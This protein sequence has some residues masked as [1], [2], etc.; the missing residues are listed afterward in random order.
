ML[1]DKLALETLSFENFQIESSASSFPNKLDTLC[2]RNLPGHFPKVNLSEIPPAEEIL[3]SLKSTILEIA[4]TPSGNADSPVG[5]TYF[6]KPHVV[7]KPLGWLLDKINEGPSEKHYYFQSQNNNLAQLEACCVPEKLSLGS[8][9]LGKQEAANLWIGTQGTTSRLHSDN[10]DNVYIQVSG[11][12]RVYLMPPGSF[13]DIDEK[14]LKP[15]TYNEHMELVPDPQGEKDELGIP[16]TVLFPTYDPSTQA[17][18]GSL[19]IVDLQPG[20][21]LFLPALWYHQVE[22]ISPGLNMSINYWYSPFEDER[23]WASWNFTRQ[24]SRILR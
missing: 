16:H 7:L 15:A 13:V 23:R 14:E 12:K 11:T 20:D 22:I 2:V 1:L 8:K 5:D 6:A 18:K 24:I 17:R 9:F 21:V 4:V 10:Y 3:D 19:W